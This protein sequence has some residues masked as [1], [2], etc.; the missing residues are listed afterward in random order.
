MPDGYLKILQ[1]QYEK[2]TGR[3]FSDAMISYVVIN[4]RTKHPIWPLV[5]KLAQ[6]EMRRLTKE[7]EQNA[8]FIQMLKP[9]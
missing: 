5:M 1:T 7:Q 9:E 8:Q 4:G 6:K 3:H 2:A